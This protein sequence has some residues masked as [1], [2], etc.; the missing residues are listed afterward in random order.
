MNNSD[1]EQIRIEKERIRMSTKVLKTNNKDF[2]LRRR[3]FFICFSQNHS[4]T[5]FDF[6][7]IFLLVSTK[8]LRMDN[9]ICN[10]PRNLICC[11]AIKL[12]QNL[13]FDILQHF[14]SISKNLPGKFVF[15]KI[16]GGTITTRSFAVTFGLAGPTT[17]ATGTQGHRAAGPRQICLRT[18]LTVH[19]SLFLFLKGTNESLLHLT[20]LPMTQNQLDGSEN[21]ETIELGKVFRSLTTRTTVQH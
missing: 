15:L 4:K 7:K 8:S 20:C 3:V 12:P 16:L 19:D 2:F 6:T 9:N 17:I 14:A 1:F 5:T 13:P 21:G 11:T 18:K 10:V